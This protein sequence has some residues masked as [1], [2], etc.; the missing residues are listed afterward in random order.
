MKPFLLYTVIIQ[1]QLPITATWT[2]YLNPHQSVSYKF[3][4]NLLQCG[5]IDTTDSGST[6]HCNLPVD[7]VELKGILS[8]LFQG[9]P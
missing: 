7:K 3:H 9:H 4:Q 8:W 6:I 1:G 5:A 2:V